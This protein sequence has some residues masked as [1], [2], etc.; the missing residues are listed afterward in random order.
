MLWASKKLSPKAHAAI[1][2]A[3]YCLAV[4]ICASHMLAVARG[5]Y[6]GVISATDSPIGNAAIECTSVWFVIWTV[7]ELVLHTARGARCVLA[8]FVSVPPLVAGVATSVP[9]ISH[10]W[11][12]SWSS[13]W[14]VAVS[15]FLPGAF[16]LCVSVWLGCFIFWGAT[17]YGHARTGPPRC[18]GCGY[19]LTGLVSERCPECGRATKS[20]GKE[21]CEVG[22]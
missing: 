12:V 7:Y 4:C 16:G 21:D 1:A 22:P 3:M 6:I 20:P 9:Q 10:E 8:I 13:G 2:V 17:R 5:W 11:A 15:A 19:N 18:S 14:I